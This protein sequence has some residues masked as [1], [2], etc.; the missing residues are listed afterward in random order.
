MPRGQREELSPSRRTKRLG[1]AA[2]AFAGIQ[3]AE[4][5]GSRSM[6]AMER[7]VAMAS[8]ATE[9]A[10]TAF[11]VRPFRQ[12]EKMVPVRSGPLAGH[13][14]AR[15]AAPVFDDPADRLPVRVHERKGASL[16]DPVRRRFR[17]REG[18]E[19]FQ[20]LVWAVGGRSGR[21]SR[22]RPAVPRSM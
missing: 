2:G 3:Q 8:V 14:Q 9:A 11:P 5:Q 1:D 16:A 22:P 18:L 7:P 15:R 6:A 21:I 10:I 13:G 20:A 19:E 12:R 4:T 17:S